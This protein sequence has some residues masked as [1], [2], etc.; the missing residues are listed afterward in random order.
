MAA[1]AK[2]ASDAEEVPASMRMMPPLPNV[3]ARL[4][5]YQLQKSEIPYHAAKNI[6]NPSWRINAIQLDI[7]LCFDR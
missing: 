7:R 3:L 4:G 2:E 5:V 1:G 6:Q